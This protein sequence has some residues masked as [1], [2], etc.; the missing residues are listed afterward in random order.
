[1]M[2][3]MYDANALCQITKEA[4][5]DRRLSIIKEELPKI[6]LKINEINYNQAKKGKNESGILLR[7][8]DYNIQSEDKQWIRDFLREQLMKINLTDSVK[9][10]FT[11]EEMMIHCEW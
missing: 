6:L 8:K 11:G 3:I 7:Y 10:T 2:E 4:I 9:E 5:A 1:M